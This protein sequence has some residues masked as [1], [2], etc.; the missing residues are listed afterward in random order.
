VDGRD[1][2]LGRDKRYFS[3]L[4]SDRL[5]GP[6]SLLYNGNHGLKW[7]G[8]DADYLPLSNEA[9]SPLLTSLFRGA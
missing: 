9:I 1:S 2:F 3:S 7:P 6:P 5:W 8:L 4:R